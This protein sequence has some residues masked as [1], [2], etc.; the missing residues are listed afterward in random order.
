[1]NK[2]EL[3][4]EEAIKRGIRNGYY[5]CIQLIKQMKL[6]DKNAT[7]DMVLEILELTY[8]QICEGILGND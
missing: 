3:I 1:M 5:S 6:I 8:K 2:E 7:I 4:I